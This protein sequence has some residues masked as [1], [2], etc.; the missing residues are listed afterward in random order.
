MYSKRG[1]QCLIRFFGT[2]LALTIT[3]YSLRISRVLFSSGPADLMTVF[4][5]FRCFD[6]LDVFLRRY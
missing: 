2:I 5:L 4:C 6:T 1:I 3:T